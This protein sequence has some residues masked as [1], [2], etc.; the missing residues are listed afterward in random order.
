MTEAKI[1]C[2]NC[3][4]NLEQ[5]SCGKC[6]DNAANSLGIQTKWDSRID[7]HKYLCKIV[8]N[9]PKDFDQVNP[10]K[11]PYYFPNFFRV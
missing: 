4:H 11:C 9:N 1:Q 7:Q 3:Q 8:V 10:L 6:V 2:V 5:S